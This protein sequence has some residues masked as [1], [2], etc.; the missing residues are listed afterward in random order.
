[1]AGPAASQSG[2]GA[3]ASLG[4]RG[5]RPLG[6]VGTWRGCE[7]PVADA[8]PRA[9]GPPCGP[10]PDRV[11][12]RCRR[13]GERQARFCHRSAPICERLSSGSGDWQVPPHP[14]PLSRGRVELVDRDSF[15][16]REGDVV[17]GDRVWVGAGR[18]DSLLTC[19]ATT[20]TEGAEGRVAERDSSVF[21][22]TAHSGVA[23][24]G[25]HSAEA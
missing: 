7:T 23:S 17:C 13:A 11:R 6:C 3:N 25:G 12:G 4:P 24:S 19:R 1:M 16:G 8:E 5:R 9:D 15:C 18:P 22:T 20:L 10:N 14:R 2:P 21:V